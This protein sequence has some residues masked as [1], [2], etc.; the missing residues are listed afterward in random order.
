MNFCIR[1]LPV[2]RRQA[3]VTHLNG[4]TSPSPPLLAPSPAVKKGGRQRVRE[5][6]RRRVREG[7][8]L[9]VE[10]ECKFVEVE[11]EKEGRKE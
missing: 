2:G 7:E 6:G 3:A 4:S 10:R 5:G 11:V 9:V 8:R 1:I